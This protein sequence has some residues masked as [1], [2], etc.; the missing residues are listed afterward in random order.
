M[1]NI[2]QHNLADEIKPPATQVGVLGWIRINLFKGW[3]N[4]CLT[5]IT[6]YILWKI[7]P[8]MFAFSILIQS[9]SRT[10]PLEIACD[11]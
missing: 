9:C 6:V 10:T 8:P 1:Q 5:I 7:V 2:D 3:L 4:S 11:N